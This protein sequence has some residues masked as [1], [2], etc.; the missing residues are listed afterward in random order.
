[1]PPSGV[2]VTKTIKYGTKQ[3]LEIYSTEIYVHLKKHRL[4]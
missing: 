4:T 2:C 1:M 3:N